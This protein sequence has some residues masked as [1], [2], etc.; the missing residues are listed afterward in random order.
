MLFE[1]SKSIDFLDFNLLI[2]NFR[3]NKK[4]KEV[5]NYGLKKY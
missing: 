2:V 1:L 3:V 4:K 5:K